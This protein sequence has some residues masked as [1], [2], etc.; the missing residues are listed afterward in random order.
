ME[1]GKN[2]INMVNYLLKENMLMEKEKEKEKNM[3]MG[4]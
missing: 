1:K 2:I 4:N 3:K